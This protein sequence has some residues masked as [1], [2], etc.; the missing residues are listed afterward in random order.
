MFPAPGGPLRV[1]HFRRRQWRRGVE[2]AGL[3]GLRIHE[4]RHT[5]VAL[6][7]AADAGPKAV[8]ARAGHTSVAFTL[9]RYGHLDPEADWLLRAVSPKRHRERGTD[10]AG[11][12]GQTGVQWACMRV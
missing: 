11:K 10:R 7:I 4:L 8:A 1:I 2:D 5:A 6:R 3:R 12:A 9:D